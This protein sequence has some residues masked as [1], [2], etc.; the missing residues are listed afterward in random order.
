MD[1]IVGFSGFVGSNL[2][3][4]HS[5]DGRYNSKNIEQAFYTKP[6]LLVYSGVPAEKF[7][8]NKF[9][10]KDLDIIEEAQ[11]NIWKIQPKKLVLISTIDVYKS[12]C[13]VDEET[14]IE[15]EGLQA[16]GHNRYKL[17][18]WVFDNKD[19]FDKILIVRLP[20]LFGQNLKKN[21]IYDMIHIIPSMLN[22]QKFD[23]LSKQSKAV[24]KHYV[25]QDNGF[26]KCGDVTKREKELL[27]KELLS[28]GFTALNFTDSRASFQFYNL[29]NL[30]EHIMIA[31]ENGLERINLATTPVRAE[32]VYEFV[33]GEV[34]EN[35][36]DRPIPDYDFRTIH[37]SLLG[38]RGGYIA[39]K[40]RILSDI[41]TFVEAEKE[42]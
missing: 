2:C 21:F 17:E 5:F 1:S 8:A 18:E 24:E 39:S 30:M 19:Q 22:Q 35:I 15:T 4:Q 37:S 11:N 40:E 16:Y 12:P 32:E 9:P 42:K 7:L 26:Y 10:E 3:A 33:T 31:L 13:G 41:K 25:L 23:E 6:D 36:I 27:K 28:L 34:F 38:G 14:K 20:G 29:V